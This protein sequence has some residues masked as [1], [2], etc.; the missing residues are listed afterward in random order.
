M[1]KIFNNRTKLVDSSREKLNSDKY[2]YR[3]KRILVFAIII[4][5]AFIVICVWK[6]IRASTDI[7]CTSAVSLPK[8]VYSENDRVIKS[9]ALCYFTYGC[10]SSNGLSGTVSELLNSKEMEILIE[11]AGIRRTDK[12][13]PATSLFD[14]SKFILKSIGHFRSLTNLSD[15]ASG[16]YGIAFCDDE[17]RCVWISYSGAVSLK[18]IWACAELVLAPGLSSQEKLAFKL[19]ETVMEGDEVKNQD[20]SV[21]L[22][23]HS[24]GG[25]LAT[26]VSRMSGCTA[27]TINGAN[28]VAL[29]KINDIVG[30]TSTKYK[31]SNYLTFPN[32]GK[33][34]FMDMVQRLMFLGSYPDIDCH[35]YKENGFTTDTHCVF[36]FITFQNNDFENPKLPDTID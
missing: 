13:N 20:Y 21:M 11:N 6:G 23:G 12:K 25:A 4:V 30:E 7:Y 29:D 22:T 3:K 32:S 8:A 35:I 34:S 18:D 26:M 1:I 27:V 5:F 28:G 14:S 15:K 33:F 2:E 9:I 16:F 24:L 36:S 17:N 31:I 19:F 10:E